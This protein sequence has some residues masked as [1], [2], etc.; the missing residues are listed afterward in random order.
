M[1][2]EPIG[3]YSK[4]AYHI[5]ELSASVHSF[6]E[7]CYVIK[8]RLYDLGDFLL[9]DELLSFIKLNLALPDLSDSLAEEAPDIAGYVKTLFSYRHYMSEDAVADICKTL[10]DGTSEMEFIRLISRGDFLSE[11][12]KYRSAILLYEHARELM[13]EG[14]ERDGLKY[15][16]LMN[17]LGKLYALY[18]MFEK[19]AECFSTAGDERR[20]FFCRK[21]TMSRVEYVDMLLKQHPDEGLSKEVEEM[22]REPAEIS[23][24]KEGLKDKSYGSR[25]ATARL[26]SRLKAEYRRIG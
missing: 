22:T 11:N 25:L 5:P 9:K 24:L 20:T 19:A 6:E 18:F 10:K 4:N 2:Y 21:L 8:E 12:K 15:K 13:D 17:K 14:D 1:I 23:E 16:E 26:C 3:V 7:L